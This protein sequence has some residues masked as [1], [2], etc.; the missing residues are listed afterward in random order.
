MTKEEVAIKF[1]KVAGV[2]ADI[3]T[4]VYKEAD[5]LRKLNH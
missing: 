1:I 4:K 5:A 2:K 3:V